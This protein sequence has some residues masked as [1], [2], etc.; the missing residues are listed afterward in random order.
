MQV[1]S[2]E[3]LDKLTAENQDKLIVVDYSTTWCGPCKL[4]LPKFEELAEE[5]NEAIFI[6]VRTHTTLGVASASEMHQPLTFS[7][8]YVRNSCF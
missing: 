8:K 4:I 7:W 3:E 6:K 2:S 1:G 5:F